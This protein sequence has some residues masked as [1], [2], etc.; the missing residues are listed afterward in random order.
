MSAMTT[1]DLVKRLASSEQGLCVAATTRPD[2]SVHASVVNAGA[3]VHPVSG[4]EVVAFVARGAARK[5]ELV[6]AARRASITF[7]RQWEWAGV[8]GP[9]EIIETDDPASDLVLAQL[10]RDIFTAAGGTHDD[11]DEFDRVMADERRVAVL[12]T[13]ERVVGNR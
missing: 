1:M 9:V 11:W 2:G 5:V 10:L 8:E 3:L 13:P 12:V 6:R 4:A 7:R